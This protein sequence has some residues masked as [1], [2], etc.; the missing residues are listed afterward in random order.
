M[1][2]YSADEFVLVLAGTSETGGHRYEADACRTTAAGLC[3]GSRV[4]LA[5]LLTVRLGAMGQF[6]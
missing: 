1:H 6:G 4:A 3:Q 2:K 5:A